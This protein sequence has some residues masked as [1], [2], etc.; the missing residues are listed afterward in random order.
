MKA[1]FHV[2]SVTFHREAGDKRYHGT[3]GARGEHNL[4]YA[5]TKWLNQRGFAVIKKRAAK[6][7][8]MVDDIQPYIRCRDQRQA[9]PHVFIISGFFALRGA[10]EDWNK[11]GKV[12]LMLH[13]DV[14]GKG[15]DTL[16]MIGQLCDQ[17][18]DMQISEKARNTGVRVPTEGEQFMDKLLDD[19]RVKDG[20]PAVMQG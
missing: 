2:S 1:E 19:W 6:D 20:V 8:H 9:Y 13:T 5:I 16:A 17:H 4:F 18:P 7:G 14:F 10:N 12:T 11:D 3:G 15:Q